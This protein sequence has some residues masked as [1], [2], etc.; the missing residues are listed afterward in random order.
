MTPPAHDRPT[1]QDRPADGALLDAARAGDAGALEALRHR[2]RG[3]AV[4]VAG[5]RAVRGEDPERI[6]DAALDRI[7]EALR[8]G[9][10]PHGFLGAFVVW[11]VAREASG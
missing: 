5:T 4:T 9:G 8:D 3:T 11:M 6:A 2:Y 1:A 7:E 10:G